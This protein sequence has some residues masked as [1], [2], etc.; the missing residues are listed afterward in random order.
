LTFEGDSFALLPVELVVDAKACVA[1]VSCGTLPRRAFGAG[2]W[3]FGAEVRV[4]FAGVEREV[5]EVAG[6][7]AARVVVLD[8]TV[9]GADPRGS[10][11][12]L[13]TFESSVFARSSG[14][15]EEARREV[16]VFEVI[17]AGDHGFGA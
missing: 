9:E 17:G 1:D 10:F 2:A 16:F 13:E 5:C 6:F 14:L 8:R 11:A 4:R 3:A 12:A 15:P 7:F